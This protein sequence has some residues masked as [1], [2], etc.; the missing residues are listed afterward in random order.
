MASLALAMLGATAPPPLMKRP[1]APSLRARYGSGGG[2]PKN[3]GAGQ[4]PAQKLPE[5]F[6]RY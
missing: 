2:G 3:A 4:P 6:R 1:A 5:P